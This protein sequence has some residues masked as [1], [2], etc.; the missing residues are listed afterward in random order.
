M[1]VLERIGVDFMAIRIAMNQKELSEGRI[2]GIPEQLLGKMSMGFE[3]TEKEKK[4]VKRRGKVYVLGH[5]KDRGQT[6][7]KPQLR[8]LPGGRRTN[9]SKY[10]SFGKLKNTSTPSEAWNIYM[11]DETTDDF[12]RQSLGYSTIE[13]AVLEYVNYL[14]KVYKGQDFES[15]GHIVAQLTEHIVKDIQSYPMT[16]PEKFQGEESWYKV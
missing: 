15:K 2:A 11:R 7:I 8:D 14:P 1:T 9:K 13:E 5:S 3:L 16:Y 10:G 12:V 6:L 4:V